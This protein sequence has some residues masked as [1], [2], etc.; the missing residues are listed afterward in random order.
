MPDEVTFMLMRHFR[1][2]ASADRA[3]EYEQGSA[4]QQFVPKQFALVQSEAPR[5]T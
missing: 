3:S 5:P 1:V 2:L 4:T